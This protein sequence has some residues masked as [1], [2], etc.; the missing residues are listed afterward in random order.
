MSARSLIVRYVPTK[1]GRVL[2]VP[3]LVPLDQLARLLFTQMAILRL[4]EFRRGDD[5]CQNR[6]F[7]NDQSRFL[8][9]T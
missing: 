2:F 9:A 5:L 3:V 7:D 1:S 8:Q 6:A 4:Q